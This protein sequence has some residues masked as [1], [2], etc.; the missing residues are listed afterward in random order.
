[1]H[2]VDRGDEPEGLETLR[3]RY[4]P[5]WVNYYRAGTGPMPND[6]RWR[7]FR[8]VLRRRFFGLCAYCEETCGGHIDHFRPKSRF[9]ELVYVWTNWLFACPECNQAKGDKWHERGYVDPCAD[10]ESERPE[11]FFDFDTRRGHIT[12]REGLSAS[13]REIANRMIE[14]L[15]LNGSHH[16]NR[17]LLHIELL[18]LSF[19]P[20][21]PMDSESIPS[22]LVSRSTELS[23]L[24][25]AWLSE[26]GYPA[27]G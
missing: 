2:W 16:V 12:P 27:G 20:D 8:G 14:D 23:T 21:Q 25:R 3:E 6:S 13:R 10:A 11:N 18:S 5:R 9:P 7:D 26:R 17:R 4:T 1:M 19:P 24:A 15:Q 22:G